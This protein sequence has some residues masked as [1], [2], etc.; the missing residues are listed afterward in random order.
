MGIESKLYS[1]ESIGHPGLP[2]DEV[3][4]MAGF[5]S[6]RC[7]ELGCGMMIGA[8]VQYAFVCIYT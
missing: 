7:C 6:R 4:C 2:R 8:Y 3:Q 1:I 5:A